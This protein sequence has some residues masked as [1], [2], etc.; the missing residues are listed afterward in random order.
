MSCRLS[1]T[2]RRL[3]RDL[4]TRLSRNQGHYRK[5]IPIGIADGRCRAVIA[6]YLVNSMSDDTRTMVLRFWFNSD[7]VIERAFDQL[8]HEPWGRSGQD[9]IPAIDVIE[10][11]DAYLISL[12]IPGVAQEDVQFSG[13]G[14][15]L[16][17]SGERHLLR[18]AQSCRAIRMER[19]Q[20]RFVRTVQL[21]HPV[22]FN[23]IEVSADQGVL[24]ARL[25]KFASG[26]S[27]P[28]ASQSSLIPLQQQSQ[29]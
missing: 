11:S 14:C 15:N 7:A 25:P 13:K 17:I 4:T 16:T 21:E 3:K 26:S 18:V 2:P 19:T 6:T 12:E 23:R 5:R 28:T 1:P 24:Y 27:L 20:G 10:V 29:P 8:I 22:D 9:W